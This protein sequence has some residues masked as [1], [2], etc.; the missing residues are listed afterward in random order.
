MSARLLLCIL[1]SLLSIMLSATTILAADYHFLLKFENRTDGGILLAD[2]TRGG[3]S[4]ENTFVLGAVIRPATGVRIRSFHAALWGKTGTVVASAV[5]AVHIKVS[6]LADLDRGS[7][8][9]IFP[10]ELYGQS[11]EGNPER[12]YDYAI[13]T[14]VPSGVYLFGGSFGPAVGSCAWLERDGLRKDWG[15]GF[16]PEL[17]DVF[18]I[19]VVA[20]DKSLA[21]LTFDNRK[22]GY[23]RAD[24]TNGTSEAVAR[25]VNPV[26]GVGYFPGTALAP[27][28]A[29][30]AA[31][32]AV[33]DV[34]TSPRGEIGGF[35]I[36][37]LLHS[38]SSEMLKSQVEPVYLIVDAIHGE[39]MMGTPPLFGDYLA[40]RTGDRLEPPL[41][42]LAG[43]E[44]EVNL[45]PGLPQVKVFADF[46]EGLGPLPVAIGRDDN[47]LRGMLR[48]VLEFSR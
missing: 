24:Y 18:V 45:I 35:Q 44:V 5:N 29:I 7:T 33:V 31:H 1:A 6:G 4:L 19:E 36:I 42:N 9:S 22:R 16:E 21:K 30:R 15:I 28:G 48:L 37:P 11:L 10:R 26:D 2:L 46:G 41:K 14:S 38:L 34:S 43:S 25:V 47:A 27:V 13:Y 39:P 3:E 8:I 12:F 20:P 17:G 23:V 32:T 40:A